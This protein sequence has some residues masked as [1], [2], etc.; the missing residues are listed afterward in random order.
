MG[1]AHKE[2]QMATTIRTGTHVGERSPDWSLPRLNGGDLGPGAVRGTKTLFF[3]WGS[4]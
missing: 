1:G 3:F 2:A 4:W